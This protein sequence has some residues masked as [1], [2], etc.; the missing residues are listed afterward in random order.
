MRR[1]Q[2]PV[3]DEEGDFSGGWIANRLHLVFNSQEVCHVTP[4]FIEACIRMGKDGRKSAKLA[5]TDLTICVHRNSA[6]R[7]K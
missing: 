6:I 7:M 2:H 4:R 1:V 3:R 5:G